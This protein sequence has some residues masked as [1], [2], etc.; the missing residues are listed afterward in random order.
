MEPRSPPLPSS[1]GASHGV[2]DRRQGCRGACDPPDREA[3]VIDGDERQEGPDEDFLLDR[4]RE[5]DAVRRLLGHDFLK[6]LRHD[7]VERAAKARAEV[8]EARPVLER[9]D[10]RV[11]PGEDGAPVLVVEEVIIFNPAADVAPH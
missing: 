2:V 8:E 7:G 3:E 9:D 11:R 10:R 6:D 4:L 1:A 5:R